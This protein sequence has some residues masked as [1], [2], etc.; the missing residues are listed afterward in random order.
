DASEDIT[1]SETDAN[2][3][4]A[5][6]HSLRTSKLS[7]KKVSALA[8]QKRKLNPDETYI[9]NVNESLTNLQDISTNQKQEDEHDY[10]G[11][12][13]ASQLRLLPTRNAII[14]Q[15]KIQSL[16]T[17][18]RL[19]C[20]SESTTSKVLSFNAPCGSTVSYINVSP[21]SNKSQ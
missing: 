10:F 17:N 3:L 19:V 9:N 5:E 8:S 7:P 15:E 13:I 11:K 20:L 18:E 2:D 4:D 14:L 6:F 12:H 1:P 21:M 16:V